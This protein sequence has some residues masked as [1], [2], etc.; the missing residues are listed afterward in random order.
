MNTVIVMRTMMLN[1]RQLRQLIAEV[2][3]ASDTDGTDVP[4]HVSHLEA[5][6]LQADELL[7]EAQALTE[8]GESAVELGTYRKAVSSAE[9]AVHRV[10]TQIR[11][12]KDGT[13]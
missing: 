3:M 4:D 12:D 10:L 2:D 11:N 8:E 9:N 6:L 5:L 13:W 7:L 1:V